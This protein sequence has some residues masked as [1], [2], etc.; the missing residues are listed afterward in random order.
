MY[1]KPQRGEPEDDPDRGRRGRDFGAT[2]RRFHSTCRN[3]WD[4]A[5]GLNAAV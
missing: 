5:A 4:S 1:I 2:I 3:G